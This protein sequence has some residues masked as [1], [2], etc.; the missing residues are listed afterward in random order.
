MEIIGRYVDGGGVIG[1][2]FPFWLYVVLCFMVELGSAVL[3]LKVGSMW[4]CLLL[5]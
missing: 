4:W 1:L 5:N 2:V 3:C